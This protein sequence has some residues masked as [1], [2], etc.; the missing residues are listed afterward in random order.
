MHGPLG[1]TMWILKCISPVFRSLS[2][3]RSSIFSLRERGMRE[4]K[5]VLLLLQGLQK[6]SSV[7][8]PMMEWERPSSSFWKSVRF[9]LWRVYILL[10]SSPVSFRLKE[11]WAW[12]TPSPSSPDRG[13]RALDYHEQVLSSSTTSGQKP[14]DVSPKALFGTY[15]PSVTHYTL[16]LPQ[17]VLGAQ[18]LRQK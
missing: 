17:E 12:F 8:Y 6:L 11:G 9:T 10:S 14:T 4:T 13:L 5:N 7:G 2:Q 1:L 15:V 18:G 3:V 16:R